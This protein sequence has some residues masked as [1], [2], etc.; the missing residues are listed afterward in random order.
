M[1]KLINTRFGNVMW[2]AEDRVDEYLAKGNRLAVVPKPRPEKK[3]ATKKKRTA[4][5]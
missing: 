5:K 3:T 1:V 2:V 4:K